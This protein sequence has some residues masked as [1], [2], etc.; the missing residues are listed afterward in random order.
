MTI[1]QFLSEFRRIV[2]QSGLRRQPWTD[3]IHTF[4]TDGRYGYCCP[5]TLVANRRLG[6]RHM[7][8]DFEIAGS[9]IGLSR[10]DSQKIARAADNPHCYQP[11][12]R[13][14]RDAFRWDRPSGRKV[15]H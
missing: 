15:G 6:V 9:K 12:R 3:R 1:D 2:R 14:L 13:K 8:C 11:L 5:I 7:T 4:D 10:E